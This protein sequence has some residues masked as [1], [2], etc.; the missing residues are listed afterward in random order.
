MGMLAPTSVDNWPVIA[1]MSLAVTRSKYWFEIDLCAQAAARRRALLLLVHLRGEDAL[2][3]RSFDRADLGLSASMMPL[4]LVPAR[5]SA[6][7]S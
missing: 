4:T 5:L 6:L 1:A 7:Y 3:T 2:L